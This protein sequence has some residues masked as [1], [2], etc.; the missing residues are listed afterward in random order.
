[1]LSLQLYLHIW[2]C[3]SVVGLNVRD[4]QHVVLLTFMSFDFQFM[5]WGRIPDR[6]VYG[7]YYTDVFRDVGPEE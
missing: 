1:M 5:I 3:C 7:I 2:Y 6:H 4:V